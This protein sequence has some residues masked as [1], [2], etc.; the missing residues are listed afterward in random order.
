M[1]QDEAHRIL[2]CS[3]DFF[4][5]DAAIWQNTIARF[6]LV[7]EKDVSDDY[8]IGGEESVGVLFNL[9]SPGEVRVPIQWMIRKSSNAA[10]SSSTVV[11]HFFRLIN[12]RFQEISF[13]SVRDAAAVALQRLN[14]Q[15][16]LP[17]MLGLDPVLLERAYATKRFP[18]QPDSPKINAV[19]RAAEIC[20]GLEYLMHEGALTEVLFRLSLTLGWMLEIE[21]AKREKTLKLVKETYELRSKTVHGVRLDAKTLSKISIAPV[22]A[23]DLLFRRAILARLILNVDE[24]RWL[25]TIR[26]TR[27]GFEI[28]LDRADW[29]TE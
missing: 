7:Y 4:A 9:L 24:D 29:V 8:P 11:E 22:M 14:S 15:L 26:R 13:A 5:K 10:A 18:L 12:G 27:L 2:A 1:T 28:E 19:S 23:T 3:Q 16:T 25:E 20:M 6:P 17:N 21:P